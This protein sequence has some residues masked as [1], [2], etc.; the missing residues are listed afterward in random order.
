MAG[1]PKHA[2]D[3]VEHTADARPEAWISYM[4]YMHKVQPLL[5][6]GRAFTASA[7]SWVI[8]RLVFSHV[9]FAPQTMRCEPGSSSVKGA[10]D[11]LFGWV[12]RRGSGQFWHEGEMFDVGEGV[13]CL[14]DYGREMHSVTAQCEVYSVMIPHARVGYDPLKHPPRLIL[15]SKSEDGA[16]VVGELERVIQTA[17]EMGRRDVPREADRFSALLATL[18]NRA[19][20]RPK[21]FEDL[22]SRLQKYVDDH[23]FDKSLS[24]ETLMET[25]DASRGQVYAILDISESLDDYIARRRMNYALRSLAFGPPDPNRIQSISD[26]CGY[27]STATFESAFANLFGVPADIAL[28]AVNTPHLR[29]NGE[30]SLGLWETWLA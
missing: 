11:I 28:G 3:P 29:P 6:P 27:A 10:P 20:P 15:D 23:I 7:E 30:G 14:F 25:F 24:L 18:L 17:D 2:F 4:S 19:G 22:Q 1:L 9:F 12:C 26:L 21:A 16:L 5:V 13:F 8:E